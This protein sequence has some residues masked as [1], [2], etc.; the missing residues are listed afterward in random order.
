MPPQRATRCVHVAVE[1]AFCSPR[2]DVK[3]Q[4][5]PE[6]GVGPRKAKQRIQKKP[7]V[8]LGTEVTDKGSLQIPEERWDACV[9]GYPHVKKPERTNLSLTPPI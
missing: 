2:S 7:R 3:L 9:S 5:L 8:C 6:C 4:H 1:E